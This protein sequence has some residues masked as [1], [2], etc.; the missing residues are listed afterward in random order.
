[1]LTILTGASWAA[2]FVMLAALLM[3]FLR[4]T[5][6]KPGNEDFTTMAHEQAQTFLLGGIVILLAL[7]VMVLAVR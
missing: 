5:K 3:A 4:A 2:G 6:Y 1:M 7:L